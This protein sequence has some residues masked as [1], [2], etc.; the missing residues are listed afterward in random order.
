[1]VLI[2]HTTYIRQCDNCG[3]E[4]EKAPSKTQMY[5]IG[6][7]RYMNDMNTEQYVFDFCNEHCKNSFL[8]IHSIRN[9][10]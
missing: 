9:V 1:M 5:T 7:K 4:I 3:V 2:T 10:E 6:V 8:S